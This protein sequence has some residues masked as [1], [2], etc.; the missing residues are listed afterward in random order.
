M[1][2][3]SYMEF[4]LFVFFTC[5]NVCVGSCLVLWL[6]CLFGYDWF[7]SFVFSCAIAK[8]GLY[9]YVCCSMINFPDR[10]YSCIYF[11]SQQFMWLPLLHCLSSFNVVSA[12]PNSCLFCI[13][14][15]FNFHSFTFWEQWKLLFCPYLLRYCVVYE[16]IYKYILA[17]SE[18]FAEI[19]IRVS[20]NN[21]KITKIATNFISCVQVKERQKAS[22]Q[23]TERRVCGKCQKERQTL[24]NVFAS[25]LLHQVLL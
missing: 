5:W 7:Y 18:V 23:V 15:F 14:W 17:I 25:L 10:W 20:I 3:L 16:A 9:S 4:S 19:L 6:L 21:I 8:R 11:C 24:H 2:F 22:P 13:I 1:Y 12:S